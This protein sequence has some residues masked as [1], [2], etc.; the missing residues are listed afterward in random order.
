MYF[1]IMQSRTQQ[2]GTRTSQSLTRP[3]AL[4]VENKDPNFDY[5]FRRKEDIDQGGGVDVY[6]YEP[7]GQGN[8]S[9]EVWGGPAG[10]AHKSRGSKQKVHL[11][12]ILC[13]RTKEVSSYFK[14]LENEKYNSQVR[15]IRDAAKNARL[16]LRDL[17]PGSVVKDE[18][19]V[20]AKV[21]T[22]RTG[23]TDQPMPEQ[24]YKSR[25]SKEEN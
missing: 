2:N 3:S 14:Q 8:S 20:S 5:S 23:P 11:D 25:V 7:V 13:R 12:T 9:G 15:F 1:F 24:S 19:Q 22:Q 21:F 4:I 16:A 18:S 6:G 17:D 10:M